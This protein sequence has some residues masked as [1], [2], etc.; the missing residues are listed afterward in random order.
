[1]P[2]L[3]IYRGI[4]ASGKSTEATRFVAQNPG[5]I[6]INRDDLRMSMFGKYRRCL[7]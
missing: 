4:P 2:T 1:M 6:R 3:Y 5:T 7:R